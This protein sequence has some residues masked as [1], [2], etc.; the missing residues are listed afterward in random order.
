MRK[1]LSSVDAKIACGK[2]KLAEKI[3]AKKKGI[4]TVEILIWIFIVIVLAVVAFSLI[5]PLF[6]K[7]KN[8][9]NTTYDTLLQ[10]IINEKPTATTPTTP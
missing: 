4:T 7:N 6:E 10:D 3:A 5:K 8:N 1:I 9:V 2:A